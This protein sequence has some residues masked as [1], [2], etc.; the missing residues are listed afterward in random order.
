MAKIIDVSRYQGVI[1]WEAVKAD[2]IQGAMLKTVSTNSAF[3]GIY[4]DPY[5]ERNYAECKRL[6]IPVGVYY[7]TYAL[8]QG[9]ADRELAKLFEALEGKTFELPIAVD[10]EDNSLK[11]LSTD[12]LTNLVAYALKTIENAGYYAILYT[13]TAYKNSELDM[14]K[15]AAFDQWRADYRGEAY[16]PANV[17]MWQYTSTA[18]VA[19]IN[20]NVDMNYAYK[21][22]PTIIRNAGLN[23]FK[24]VTASAPAMPAVQTEGKKS[25]IA[26]IFEFIC[27]LFGGE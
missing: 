8:D 12:A 14:N 3:G 16:K 20:G 7:Y 23:G 18:R 10:V 24:K 2:G 13:Y 25:L 26:I 1:D 21:D 5:F 22:Y 9:Y 27:R 19:G 15:L 11:P 4:I 6:G 17:G